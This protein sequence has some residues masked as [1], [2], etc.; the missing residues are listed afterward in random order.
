MNEDSAIQNLYAIQKTA[1]ETGNWEPLRL[2]Y[3][4]DKI[5]FTILL[6]QLHI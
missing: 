1:L 5:K 6:N 4:P 2:F 3:K